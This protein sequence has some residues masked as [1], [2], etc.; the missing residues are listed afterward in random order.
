MG[1]RIYVEKV[2]NRWNLKGETWFIQD[3]PALQDKFKNQVF[4][5]KRDVWIDMAPP[6]K[7]RGLKLK[8]WLYF[9]TDEDDFDIFEHY[10]NGERIK[11]PRSEFK[12]IKVK[13][14]AIKTIQLS[15]MSHNTNRA[16]FNIYD[17]LSDNLYFHAWNRF[18]ILISQSDV[19]WFIKWFAIDKEK[20]RELILN[21]MNDKTTFVWFCW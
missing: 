20:A 13:H 8:E 9:E 2:V 3:F 10:K 5:K 18:R 6:F 21:K 12:Q 19:E 15:V 1:L 11:I 14:P 7:E 16:W 4:L 17:Y